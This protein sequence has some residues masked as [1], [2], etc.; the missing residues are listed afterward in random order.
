[1]KTTP[2]LALLASLLL[3]PMAWAA[4]LIVIAHPSVTLTADEVR[5]VFVG[6]KQLAGAVKLVPMDN[7]AA[8][9]DFL[10]KVVKVDTAKYQSIWTKKGFRDGVQAPSVKSGDAEVIAAVKAT[11]G[12]VGYVTKASADVKVIQKL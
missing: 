7:A 10:A 9:A 3:S 2:I 12:A 1:M 6:D 11:P 5:D 8:Q 4:D